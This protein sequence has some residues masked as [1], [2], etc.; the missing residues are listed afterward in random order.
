MTAHH[1][2]F[3]DIMYKV[4]IFL[5]PTPIVNVTAPNTQTVGQSLTLQCEVTTVRGITSRVDI[6]W[7][8][9]GT[10]LNRTDNISSTT[11]DNSLVYTDCYTISQLSTDDEGRDYW[12]EVVINSDP[13]ITSSANVILDV[14]GK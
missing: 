11:I 3:T 2:S 5:V 12:C 8:S 7:S 1:Y 10:E 4:L 14:S 13:S 9:G 6:V